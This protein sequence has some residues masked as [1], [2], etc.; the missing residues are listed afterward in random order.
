MSSAFSIQFITVSIFS[1]NEESCFI[2]PMI[3][4]LRLNVG[5]CFTGDLYDGAPFNIIRG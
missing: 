4:N 2:V 5:L 3:V 1:Q